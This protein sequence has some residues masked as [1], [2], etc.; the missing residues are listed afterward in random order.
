M[1]YYDGWDRNVD[2]VLARQDAW[3][4]VEKLFQ[5]IR[6]MRRSNLTFKD[7]R[8]SAFEILN[9]LPCNF[10]ATKT[11]RF[12]ID[13]VFIRESDGEWVGKFSHL[14]TLLQDRRFDCNDEYIQDLVLKSA[15]AALDGFMQ[16]LREKT[17][18]Y[19]MNSFEKS[20][21]I[22]WNPDTKVKSEP[23]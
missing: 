21:K 6:T 16:K 2:I 14:R 5:V 11:T 15:Y 7:D 10:P 18:I 12:P 3:Y 23:K 17:L 19:D 20:L 1:G 13:Q 4:N 22:T 8:Q 9:T